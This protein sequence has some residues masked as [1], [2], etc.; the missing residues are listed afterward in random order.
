M[1]RNY[2]REMLNVMEEIGRQGETP[3]LLLHS[4]C[5][6]CSTVCLERLSE[7]F[8]VTVYYYNPNIF[9]ETGGERLY[10]AFSLSA[11]GRV[12]GC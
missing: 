12:S 3:R 1:K 9:P 8:A 5:A 7:S 10:Q 4:C 6:P 2:D 11:S